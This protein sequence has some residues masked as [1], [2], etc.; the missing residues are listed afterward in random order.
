MDFDRLINCIPHIKEILGVVEKAFENYDDPAHDISHVLRVTE[1]AS[2]IAIRE[3]ANLEIAVIAALL[4][5]IKR[6]EEDF[7]G[8]D[9]AESGAKYAFQLLNEMGFES[10]FTFEVSEAIKVHRY[11]SG[12]NPSSM[13][14]RI[15]Q[16][17]DRLDA[18]GAIAVAR[19]FFIF[20]KNGNSSSFTKAQAR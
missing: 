15:L 3:G 14:A 12:L 18:I 16:D 17:A 9:H 13:S 1:S 2:E 11:S 7:T 5:D 4:H 20:G 10:Q 8:I 19:V 6:P